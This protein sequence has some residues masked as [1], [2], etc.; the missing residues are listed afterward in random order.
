MSSSTVLLLSVCVPCAW[1]Q[2]TR[3]SV[4]RSRVPVSELRPG[5]WYTAGTDESVSVT[6]YQLVL[7]EHTEKIVLHVTLCDNMIHGHHIY[8]MS[9]HNL[10]QYRD[11]SVTIVTWSQLL[12]FI[13]LSIWIFIIWFKLPILYLVTKWIRVIVRFFCN[14]FWSDCALKANSGS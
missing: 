1:H 13:R 2:V 10:W 12:D 7:S 6:R 9:W 3:C 5:K 4:A 8:V 11:H 14:L